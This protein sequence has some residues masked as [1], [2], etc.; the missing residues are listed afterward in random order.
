[1]LGP[2]RERD[3]MI[4]TERRFKIGSVGT[5]AAWRARAVGGHWGIEK[6]PHLSL[7]V[8][9]R[10]DESCRRGPQARKAFAV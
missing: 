2:R 8:V 6:D 3:R 4:S 7:G 5:D 9:F 1:M 10:E